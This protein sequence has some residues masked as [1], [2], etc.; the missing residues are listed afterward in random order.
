MINKDIMNIIIDFSSKEY[1]R[2]NENDMN[3]DELIQEEEWTYNS[4]LLFYTLNPHLIDK[5][6]KKFIDDNFIN[7]FLSWFTKYT[8]WSHY[9]WGSI[10]D[11]FPKEVL[12]KELCM[13]ILQKYIEEFKNIPK[14]LCDEDIYITVVEYYIDNKKYEKVFEFVRE[15]PK[16]Y[17]NH[18]RILSAIACAYL[19]LIYKDKLIPENLKI[20]DLKT[21]RTPKLSTAQKL[22]IL[23]WSIVD[24]PDYCITKELIELIFY[25]YENAVGTW[26]S[27]Y[28]RTYKDIEYFVISPNYLKVCGEDTLRAECE[29]YNLNYLDF[30]YRKNEIEQ[31]II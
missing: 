24:L 15:I 3:I 26:T 7:I 6:P 12:T 27:I 23:D 5:I 19:Q 22:D 1:S 18:K 4:A 17:A 14:E 29:K 11:K 31:L 13:T 9:D 30:I 8:F 10:L 20:I 25:Y 16:E 21:L 2:G 28:G